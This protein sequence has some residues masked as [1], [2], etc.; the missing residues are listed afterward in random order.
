MSERVKSLTLVM[1]LAMASS[2]FSLAVIA[3]LAADMIG[4]FGISREQLGLL[5]TAAA[6]TGAALAPVLGPL[7]D[8]LGARAATLFSLGASALA[9]AVMGVAPS[10]WWLAL[11]ALLS[12]VPQA[13]ANPATNML[14]LAH[15]PA[16]RR[17]IV[18]GIKSSGVQ[19]G[20]AVGGLLLSPIAVVAG[21]R[22]GVVAAAMIPVGCLL[23]AWR[24]L[25]RDAPVR[26]SPLVGGQSRT[27]VSRLA[28]YGFLLGAG[29]TA[30]ATFLP[31]FGQ[32]RL[33][34]SSVAAGATLAVMG[35]MGII[36][37]I[38]WGRIAEHHLGAEPT[39]VILAAISLTVSV[40]LVFASVLGAWVI[41]PVAVLTGLSA[42]SW[43]A[44]GHLAIIQQVPRESTGRASGFLMM[45]F[46]SGVGVGAPLFGRSVDLF[47]G[48]TPGWIGVGVTFLSAFLLMVPRLGVGRIA[49]PASHLAT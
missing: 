10:F 38:G 40:A 22:A 13:V 5:V 16:G 31:L 21:W 42:S 32:E 45:G 36:G 34:L 27:G 19:L 30:V 25:P 7:A 43:N 14:I 26:R 29:G 3:A 2:T 12:G 6:F 28:L 18:T 24:D 15:V 46:L 41:W 48:Y 9:L 20:T 4:E 37:R 49:E 35:V 17:G 33:G 11:G 44:L 8:R 1:V 23:L 39:L 47:G